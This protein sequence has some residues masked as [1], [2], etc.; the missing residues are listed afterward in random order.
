MCLH[1]GN[2]TYFHSLHIGKS[3]TNP[4][5]KTKL[6]PNPNTNHN[7]DLTTNRSKPSVTVKR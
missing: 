4:Y 5:T 7:P 6:N 3:Y 2:P 1:V